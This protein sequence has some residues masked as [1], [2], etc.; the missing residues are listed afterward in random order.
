MDTANDFRILVAEDAV[1]R[2]EGIV[3]NR[4]LSLPVNWGKAVEIIRE[5]RSRVL[6]I[7]YMYLPAHQL[8]HVPEIAEI[9][10]LSVELARLVL[11]KDLIR[12]FRPD[13]LVVAE[14]RYAIRVLYG[15]SARILL[16]D[17]N[18]PLYAIDI[19]GV[20]VVSIHKHPRA[21]KLYI[22]KAEGLLP[23]TII[24]NISDLKRGEVRAAAML[25]PA[26][27]M[28]EISEAMYC[29]GPIDPSYKG[30]RPPESLLYRDEVAAK[31]YGLVRR[32]QR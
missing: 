3:R 14:A 25:P 16:G 6:R 20:E 18:N 7:K 5:L 28:G 32:A 22:T 15:L 30:K 24:T 31:I 19:E 11:D 26:V 12:R 13:P 1:S 9:R 21:D 2:L 27:L 29:S 4:R 17:E 10:K 8:A 23:Y